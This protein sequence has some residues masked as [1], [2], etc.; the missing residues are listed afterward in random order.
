MD[1]FTDEPINDTEQVLDTPVEP[2]EA[3]GI[4][5]EPVVSAIEQEAEVPK[6]EDC[7][8]VSV[9][10]QPQKESDGQNAYIS[11]L[12]ETEVSSVYLQKQPY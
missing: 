4:T 11:F 10:K 1:E 7:H 2:T 6:D 9:V 8:T 5:V 12:V 3:A